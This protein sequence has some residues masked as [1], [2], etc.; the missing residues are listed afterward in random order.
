MSDPQGKRFR[1]R[2]RFAMS[3]M[4]LFVTAFAVG[5]ATYQVA[6]EVE[7][8]RR[9]IAVTE[10]FVRRL[11]IRDPEQFAAVKRKSEW[12]GESICD[13]YIPEGQEFELC[14]ATEGVDEKG[15]ALQYNRVPLSSGEHSIEVRNDNYS[16][17]SEVSVLV[18]AVAVMEEGKPREWNPRLGSSGGPQISKSQ[19]FLTDEPLILYRMRFMFPSEPGISTTP[20]EPSPGIL[21]WIQKKSAENGSDDAGP[22]ELGD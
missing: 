12:F 16:D 8:L 19:Q 5:L 3:T 10:T 17:R 20:P 1:L 14:L 21:V 22:G 2:P 15:L 6:Q 9:Q 11:E 4:L 18:D 13:V 7:K